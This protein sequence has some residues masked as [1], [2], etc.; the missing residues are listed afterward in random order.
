MHFAPTAQKLYD[1]LCADHPALKAPIDQ[2][3]AAQGANALDQAALESLLIQAM[4]DKKGEIE[5]AKKGCAT[6]QCDGKNG[7]FVSQLATLLIQKDRDAVYR[8][9]QLSR[10]ARDPLFAEAVI[11][12]DTDFAVV[13]NFGVFDAERKPLAMKVICRERADMSKLP[14]VLERYHT[15]GDELDI[16]KISNSTAYYKIEDTDEHEFA[17]GHPAAIISFDKKAEE[18]GRAGKTRPE[19]VR[20]TK[21]YQAKVEGGQQVPNLTAPV[22]VAPQRE[23]GPNLDTTPVQTWLST[24]SAQL[25]VVGQLASPAWISEKLPASAVSL[26]LNIGDGL[27]AEPDTQ[28]TVQFSGASATVSVAANDFS[29]KGSEERVLAIPGNLIQA[30]TFHSLLNAAVNVTSRSIATATDQKAEQVKMMEL[31]YPHAAETE[32]AGRQ[33]RPLSE[34]SPKPEERAAAKLKAAV[35]PLAGDPEQNGFCARVELEPG[36]VSGKSPAN[37]AGYTVEVGY[38]APD[39]SWKGGEAF[40][41]SGQCSKAMS[42]EL[43]IDDVNAAIIANTQ[44]EIR[45]RNAEGVPA[46]RTLLPVKTLEWDC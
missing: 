24:L 46:T 45:V 2:A 5:Q 15:H 44:L 10:P 17:F 26:K 38:R 4:P 31:V 22:N 7:Q 14:K 3:V 28:A 27:I 29:A 6:H 25:E 11:A 8:A 18:Q 37:V 39:G 35:V 20:V 43:P 42:F 23:T 12:K 16:V 13:A 40:K 34:F 21:F 32:V 1:R 19:N 9:P 33:L 41:V 30:Q 36:F